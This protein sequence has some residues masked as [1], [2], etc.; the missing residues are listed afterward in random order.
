M[1][2]TPEPRC[3][4]LPVRFNRPAATLTYAASG[5]PTGLPCS[6]HP[7]PWPLVRFTVRVQVMPLSS[8]G[9]NTFVSPWP[10]RSVPPVATA[11]TTGV[12]NFVTRSFR[13]LIVSRVLARY[14]GGFDRSCE[15]MPFDSVRNVAPSVGAPVI[16]IDWP[17]TSGVEA[18]NS[19]AAPPQAAA[20]AREE[21]SKILF[22]EFV[23]LC[24]SGSSN[25]SDTPEDKF[26]KGPRSTGFFARN[27]SQDGGRV[28]GAAIFRLRSVQDR[29]IRAGG[30]RA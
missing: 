1:L 5:L 20:S 2:V 11:S 6:T 21:Q 16:S 15:V 27:D 14:S 3:S 30:V 19:F 17:R 25:P 23:L 10:G 4:A 29:T 8:L 7:N 28:G 13:P 12:R 26:W 22:M 24:G 18:A 9:P